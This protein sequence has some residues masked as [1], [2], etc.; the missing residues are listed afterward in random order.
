ML[1]SAISARL[2]ERSIHYGWVV[3]ATAF[4][5]MLVTAGT[6]GAPSVL[7]LPLQREFGWE[8]SSIS[9]ALAIRFFLFG[10]M[11]PFAAALM[12]RYGLR[13]MALTALCIIFSGMGLSLFMTEL[14]QLIVLWGFVIGIGTGLT[15]MV[16]GATIAT[17]WFTARRGF[18][19][20]LLTASTATGQLV[21][22]PLVAALTEAYGWHSAVIFIIAMLLVCAVAMLLFMRD[23]PSDLG[24]RPYGQT[25][26]EPPAAAALSSNSPIDILI[27]AAKTRI[28]WVLFL[29]FFVCGL[30]TN[31]LI[32]THFVS[33]CADYG[34]TPVAATGFLAII[35]IFDFVGT[36]ASGW[37]SDR[38]D[39]RWLLFWYYGLR[40]LSLI[41]LPFTGF[42]FIG[43]SVFAV[44]YGLDWIATVPPTVKLTA[45]HFGREKANMV[46]GWVFFGHQV[47]AATAAFGGG[48]IRDSY[49]SY[50]PALMVAGIA[51]LIIAP[52]VLSGA[53]QRM[54]PAAA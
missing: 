9:A 18:V 4:L 53:R 46:F 29:S 50:L 20:G 35:G 31:G 40:G 42:E 28:F 24:L 54:Q 21:F 41:W 7:L 26:D 11:A 25:V 3:A 23:R 13:R 10:L 22:M 16:M 45:Q 8:A 30:S 49:A 51:C 33:L 27:E 12:N 5:T 32:Q 15:A 17:R 14:W 36:V 19:V 34:M 37:L 52:F 2:S 38:Y 43:L 6:I 47:G 39:N 1:S 44:F 48:Y